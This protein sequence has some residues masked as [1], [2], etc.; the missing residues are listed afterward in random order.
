MRRFP[1]NQNFKVLKISNISLKQTNRMNILLI[2]PW[3]NNTDIPLKGGI[4][5]HHGGKTIR[6]RSQ[7]HNIE[8]FLIKVNHFTEKQREK[9]RN[10]KLKTTCAIMFYRQV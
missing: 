10:K 9:Q 2:P 3:Q 8:P 7:V 4:E 1:S 5:V 6:I